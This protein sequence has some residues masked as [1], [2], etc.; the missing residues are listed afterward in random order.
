MESSLVKIDVHIIF[1][2]KTTSPRI[3]SDDLEQVFKY[4]KGVITNIGGVLIQ[5]GGVSD[6]IHILSSLP[7]NMCV[8]D[9]VKTIKV[10]SSKWIKTINSD[11]HNFA[12]QSGYGAFSVSPS[13]LDNTIRYIK[14]QHEHH[15]VKT[16]KE[17]YKMFL[18]AYGIEYDERYIFGD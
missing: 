4:I 2:I 7:Q 15:R 1:H 18:D 10:A 17:E 11:Y 16:F 12:W 13:I 6:H 9:F 3:L 8:S 5:I 14:N